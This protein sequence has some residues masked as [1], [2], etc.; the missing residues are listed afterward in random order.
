[1]RYGATHR[2]FESRPLRHSPD[3]PALVPADPREAIG[4]VAGGRVLDV[5]TGRGGFVA[6]LRDGLHDFDEIVGIDVNPAGAEAFAASF[7]D[8]PRIRFVEMD[9][10]R[11]DFPPASFHTVSISSSLHHVID[12]VCTATAR[13]GRS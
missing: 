6:I 3:E 8:D 9:A 4:H 11:T 2:G 1:M 5:A 7:G 12:P 13:R 10:L